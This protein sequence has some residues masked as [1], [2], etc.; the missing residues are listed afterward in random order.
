MITFLLSATNALK[1]L[2]EYLLLNDFPPVYLT[3]LAD[4]KAKALLVH[5]I[6]RKES[7]SCGFRVCLH[8]TVLLTFWVID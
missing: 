2:R 4:E 5:L 1:E 7:Y 3:K 8:T 6:R